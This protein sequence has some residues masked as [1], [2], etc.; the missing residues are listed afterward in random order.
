MRVV[1]H[2]YAGHPFQFELSRALARRGH[3]VG[4]MFFE[5]DPGPKGASGVL[6]DD[7]AN[8]SIEPISIGVPY[9]KDK[10]LRRYV[11]DTLYGRVAGKRIAAFGP[12][13]VISGNTPLSAQRQ[14]RV[15]T[16]ACGARFVFWVQDFYAVAIQRLLAG[17]FLGAG[18][19]VARYY[20][21]V[22]EAL[23]RKS[24]AIVLISADFKP[25]L[26]A[27]VLA[28]TKLEVI[29]NWGP[30]QEIQPRQKVNPWS[31]RHGL[32]DRF[33]FMYTG[34]LGLK[35]D[36]DLLWALSDAFRDD[37]EVAIV[38]AAVGMSADRLQARHAA[39]PRANLRLLPLQPM[40]VFADT[41]GA[42][43]VLVALLED[44]AGTFS[45]PSKILSYLC[46]GRA[47]LLS[48]PS[49][50]LATRVI[51]DSG[52]GLAMQSGDTPAF[53]EAARRLRRN[54]AERRQFAAAARSYAEVNFD[55]SDV[56]T[57][58]EQ[59]ID[60]ACHTR[61]RRVPAAQGAAS[62]LLEV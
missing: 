44:S 48:A 51:R 9:K 62:P 54:H 23:F 57:R 60:R 19:A 58:F 18:D 33:V 12:D 43:D 5:G 3:V 16:E 2:D 50:N 32:S 36:P 28:D 6:P 47:I 11:A 25:M 55:I 20:A 39:D 37:D 14:I 40:E 10:L 8:L 46:A 35:H 26:P 29:G 61:T 22:E 4:H 31:E 27:S 21:R 17:R 59:V 34:T 13:V 38:V 45:V 52:G 1:I 56:A 7:P 49:D 53:I 41:L 42:A 30:M 15:A 24:D